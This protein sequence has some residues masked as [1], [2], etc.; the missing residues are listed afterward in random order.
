[1]NGRYRF[2]RRD[3]RRAIAG[4]AAAFAAI[5]GMPVLVARIL[6]VVA[7]M[8]GFG[9]PL[10]VALWFLSPSLRTDGEVVSPANRI[11]VLALLLLMPVLFAV[12]M[13]G[14]ALQPF[15]AILLATGVGVGGL[16]VRR[17]RV[18]VPTYINESE[19]AA[20]PSQYSVQQ[21]S[22]RD[23]VCEPVIVTGGEEVPAPRL[24]GV[25]AWIS[26]RTGLNVTVVRIMVV[27]AT[28]FPPTFPA[29]PFLYGFAIFFVPRRDRTPSH[30][31]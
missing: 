7:A 4:V 14:L 12:G 29:I 22:F 30:V 27:A 5:A 21:V 16:M 28:V 23:D 26:G 11:W 24:G 8:L 10:Y 1:M 17:G 9:I 2:I 6:F 19:Q 3:N 18:V 25:C 15:E 31:R 13:F 20:L